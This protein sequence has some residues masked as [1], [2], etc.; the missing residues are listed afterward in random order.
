MTAKLNM[1]N[2]IYVELLPEAWDYIR[3]YYEDLFAR[4]GEVGK[5]FIADGMNYWKLRTQKYLVDGKFMDL[6]KIQ[7]HEF[8]EM[9][10]P[11]VHLGQLNQLFC[12]DM[13]LSLD[14]SMKLPNE[15]DGKE[16]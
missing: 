16:D 14:E 9:F 6:T 13:Y 2:S 4:Y 5:N 8:M 15:F 3:K 10:G 12:N 11:T 7:M 1:N